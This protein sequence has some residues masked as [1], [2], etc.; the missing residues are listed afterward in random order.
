MFNKL[1]MSYISVFRVPVVQG[2]ACLF[3]INDWL[4]ILSIKM[5]SNY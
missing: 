2:L 1:L 5:L 4:E 3:Q